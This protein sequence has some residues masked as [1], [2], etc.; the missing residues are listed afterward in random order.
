MANQTGLVIDF[1]CHINDEYL[2]KQTAGKTVVTGFGTREPAKSKFGPRNRE[3]NI[4]EVQIE[5][6]DRDGVDM[7][8]L[9]LATVMQT[10]SWAP[11]PQELELC[12]HANDTVAGWVAKYPKRFIPSFVLPLQDMRLSMDEF[13]RCVT[14]LRMPVIQLPSVVKGAYIGE[15]QFKDLWDA[16][17]E[18][19]LIA[20]IH[21]EGTTDMWYQKFRMWNSL[22]QSVEEAKVICSLIYE[23]VLERYPGIKVVISHGGGMLPFNMGRLDRNVYNMPDSM[24]NISK[25]PSEYLRHLYFDTCVYQTPILERLIG[26]VGADRVVFG[27]DYPVGDPDRVGFVRSPKNASPEEIA[28][29]TGGT[30]AQLLGLNAQDRSYGTTA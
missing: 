12:R 24:V 5:D 28:L 25:K 6:M 16:I 18:K 30:A 3:L 11:A 23:G 9:T 2:A 15:P 8:L 27:S 4:P 17:Y 10:T 29:M 20:F 1:H 7:N 22:G 19:K 21:P 26:V 13:E 14:D